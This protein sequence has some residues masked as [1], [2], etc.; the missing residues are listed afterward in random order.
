MA[1]CS[2]FWGPFFLVPFGAIFG[3]PGPSY[4]AAP[5]Q[6]EA[7]E[8]WKTRSSQSWEWYT[9]PD[10]IW[11]PLGS[12]WALFGFSR[13]LTLLEVRCWHSLLR[14]VG[15]LSVPNEPICDL[16]TPCGVYCPRAVVLLLFCLLTGSLEGTSVCFCWS[17]RVT[18]PGWRPGLFYL[19]C[20]PACCWRLGPFLACL[21]PQ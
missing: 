1:A 5:L 16:L 8:I 20:D 6:R 7:S 19:C 14:P 17:E 10:R 9:P 13:L 18:L 11:R 2:P 12:L 21:C 4:M 3:T 15:D